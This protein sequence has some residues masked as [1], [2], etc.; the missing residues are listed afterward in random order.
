MLRVNSLKGEDIDASPQSPQWYAE[1]YR[2]LSNGVLI[3]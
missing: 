3:W 2:S 1:L